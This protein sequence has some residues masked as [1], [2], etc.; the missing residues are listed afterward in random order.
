MTK[1]EKVW[2]R[3]KETGRFMA[4]RQLRVS[5]PEARDTVYGILQD[6]Q[7]AETRGDYVNM[8]TNELV[9]MVGE[10]PSADEPTPAVHS[11]RC[12]CGHLVLQH[13][14]GG[15]CNACRDLG[16]HCRS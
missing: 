8:F 3:I 11:K 5:T 4:D 10:F 9:W 2:Q 7:A 13:D 15:G 1:M 14:P 16:R 6:E 12:R